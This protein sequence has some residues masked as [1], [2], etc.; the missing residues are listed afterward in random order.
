MRFGLFLL[1]EWSGP[2]R[3][4]DAMYG[5]LSGQPQRV[6]EGQH[7]HAGAEAHA[8]RLTG[9]FDGEHQRLRARAVADEVVL[10]Q[11]HRLQALLL[12]VG[13]L[14]EEVVVHR[15]EAAAGARPLEEQ[16]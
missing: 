12:G 11:P 4:F 15:V 10:S 3:A 14:L 9:R 2:G 16:E 1:F 8:P 5:D 7:Q 13:D 6:I